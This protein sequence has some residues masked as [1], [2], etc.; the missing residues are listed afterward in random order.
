MTLQE[1]LDQHDFQ[2]EPDTL[3]QIENLLE[4]TGI[5][6]KHETKDWSLF[7]VDGCIVENTVQGTRLDEIGRYSVR[8]WPRHVE[9]TD[10]SPAGEDQGM[11]PEECASEVLSIDLPVILR[12]YE[13]R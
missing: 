6:A 9:V 11:T 13:E 4:Q 3:A 10:M 2:P 7:F 1:W 5:A 8:S 12:T